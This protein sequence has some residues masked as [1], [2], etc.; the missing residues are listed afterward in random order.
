MKA[1]GRL[2]EQG[3][4]LGSQRVH[5]LLGFGTGRIRHKAGPQPSVLG[6]KPIIHGT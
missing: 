2:I 6:R 4:Q 5:L 1:V 3:L